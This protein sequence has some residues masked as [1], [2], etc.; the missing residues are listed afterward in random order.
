[1][2]NSDIA[3][4]MQ[5]RRLVEEFSDTVTRLCI[6]HTG[7]YAD[8]E[9]CYQ[10]VF[11][12]LFKALDKG[13]IPNPKAW[14]IKVTLNECRSVLRYRLRKNTV[15]LNEV[16]AAAEDSREHEMLDL[17]FR[18]P[19]KYRDVIYLHYYEELSVEEISEATKT[20]VNTVKSQLKRGR[21]K[22]R[23]FME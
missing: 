23:A 21:E 14:I 22:L 1:M 3:K 11:F 7:N 20:N 19:S 12:K 2:K 8:A 16:T 10:N 17:V 13:K 4:E 6:V 5:Y 18:L 15:D 9:D